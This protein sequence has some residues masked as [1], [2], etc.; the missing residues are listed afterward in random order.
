MR[1]AA[2]LKMDTMVQMRK[3]AADTGIELIPEDFVHL[4]E[5]RWETIKPIIPLLLKFGVQIYEI[6]KYEG[7]IANSQL[8]KRKRVKL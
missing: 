6:V 7:D 3:E 5:L 4:D 8:L 1:K 2:F